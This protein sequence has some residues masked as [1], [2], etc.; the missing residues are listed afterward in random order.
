MNNHIRSV[1]QE[2]KRTVHIKVSTPLWTPSIVHVVYSA[3]CTEQFKTSYMCKQLS[4]SVYNTLF[5]SFLSIDLDKT[6]LDQ[7]LFETPHVDKMH[8]Y[9]L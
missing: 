6:K 5:E 3:K 1:S 7:A 4:S 2:A 9:M 8:I